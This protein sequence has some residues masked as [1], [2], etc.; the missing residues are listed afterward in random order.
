MTDQ[1][2]LGI[3]YGTES[4]RVA[5]FTADGRPVTFA[6]TPYVTHRPRP[7][8]AE[9]SP[10]DWWDALVSSSNQ[11]ISD[12][13]IKPEQILG[14][15][16]DA[17]SYSLVPMNAERERT[18]GRERGLARLRPS[19]VAICMPR[20]YWLRCRAWSSLPLRKRMPLGSTGPV[21]G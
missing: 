4:C 11:A 10:D 16:Y 9:Q 14:I 3:D 13:G 21:A 1:Y 5:I 12:S 20:A 17:T 18:N 15:G 7:G 2:L 8:W 6:A 19:N